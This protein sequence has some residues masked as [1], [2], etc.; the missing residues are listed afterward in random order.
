MA[1]T[2]SRSASIAATAGVGASR[3]VAL[4]GMRFGRD[5]RTA[6][7]IR[8]RQG[9]V[10]W[11]VSVGNMATIVAFIVASTY[12]YLRLG[13]SNGSASSSSSSV[14]FIGLTGNKV[15]SARP[16]VAVARRRSPPLAAARRHSHAPR[17]SRS[18]ARRTR[19]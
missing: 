4:G 8:G 3:G 9:M 1:L 13:G 17:L 18:H 16:V 10:E 7:T 2:S 19:R 14:S 12:I 6:G 11:V 15:G 5:A